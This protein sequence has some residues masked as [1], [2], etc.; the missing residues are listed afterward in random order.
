MTDQTAQHHL[1]I[2]RLKLSMAE[3]GTTRPSAAALKC[4][5]RFVTALEALDVNAPV[6]FAT[7]QDSERFTDV[8]SGLLLADVPLKDNDV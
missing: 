5:R 4:F 6:R 1:R 3:K 2:Y 7:T 8:R